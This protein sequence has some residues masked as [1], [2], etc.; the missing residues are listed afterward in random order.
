MRG[1]LKEKA[2][3]PVR[4]KECPVPILLHPVGGLRDRGFT[5]AR[6]KDRRGNGCPSD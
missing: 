6:V 2:N 5:C 1:T 3:L 4:S